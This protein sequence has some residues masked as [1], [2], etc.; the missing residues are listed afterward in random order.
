MPQL[1][2]LCQHWSGMAGSACIKP[3]LFMCSLFVIATLIPKIPKLQRLFIISTLF[4]NK[5][6]LLKIR[7]SMSFIVARFF[8]RSAALNDIWRFH[9]QL[10]AH[11]RNRHTEQTL[12]LT[13]VRAVH[14]IVGGRHI[15]CWLLG[16]EQVVTLIHS[17]ESPIRQIFSKIATIY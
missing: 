15:G 10:C 17:W 2:S 8:T 5:F 16:R 4:T 1:Q 6:F 3:D 11:I 12:V 13:N 14:D 9:S 7:L